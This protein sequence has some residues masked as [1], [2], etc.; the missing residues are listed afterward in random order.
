[1]KYVHKNQNHRALCYYAMN[2]HMYLVKDPE[3][4][5]SSTVNDIPVM[6]ISCFQCLL[7]MH[8]VWSA[9]IRTSE[10]C[11]LIT[12][13]LK[14]RKTGQDTRSFPICFTSVFRFLARTE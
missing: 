10:A 3:L 12:N 11:K 4:V 13:T 9:L 14:L 1:M 5:K 7:L 8:E 2:N 6:R